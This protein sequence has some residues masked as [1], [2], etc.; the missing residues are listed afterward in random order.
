ELASIVPPTG[1]VSD[2]ASLQLAEN[3][4]KIALGQAQRDRARAERLLAAGAV[5]ARRAEE[6]R[7]VEATAQARLQAAQSRLAQ[8]DATRSADGAESGVRR[9]LVRAPIGGIISEAKAISGSNVEI[10]TILFRIVD[11]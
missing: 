8:Y 11:T 3:E 7:A 5:P 9:F 4:A 6:A 10:G 2:P 1:A